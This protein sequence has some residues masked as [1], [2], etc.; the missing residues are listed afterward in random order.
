MKDDRNFG[1]LLPVSSLPSGEGIGTLGKEAYDFIDFLAGS[2][3]KIWQVLPLNPTNYGD[4]PYQSCSSDALNYYFIDLNMLCRDGLLK[5]SEIVPEE[6]ADTPLRVNY[7]RQFTKKIELLKKAFSRFDG[8]KEFE[9]FVKKGEYCDFAVFMAIKEKFN[10]VAWTEWEQ[11][12]RKYDEKTVTNF[13]KENKNE[14]L[15]WQFTQFIFLKQWNALKNY[16]AS[17]GVEIMGD[18]PL[19]VAYD[20]VEVWKYGGELFKVD[21]DR[22]LKC[23]AGCPPDGFTADGQLWGNPVYNWERMRE[24]GYDWWKARIEKCF[25]LFDILRIDHFRGF[26]RY[27]EVPA[28]DSTARY[29]LW[30]DGPKEELFKDI[31]DYKIV[32]E[33]LGVIDDGVRRLMKNVG[34]PGMKVLEFAFDGDE[35]NEHKPSN[36]TENFVCYTGTHDNMPLKQYIDD[37]SEEERERFISDVE[38]ESGLLKLTALTETSEDLCRSVVNLAFASKADTVIIPLWD[39]LALGGEARINKPSTVSDSNWS[40]R[41]LKEDFSEELS[42]YLKKVSQRSKRA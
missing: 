23:V 2:G 25:K 16:A 24:S 11:P 26:D 6:L 39:L 27:W 4:S 29:G 7:G 41:F 5:K 15:F 10:H 14:Y 42:A 33:D 3:G 37:L 9:E 12:F 18:I 40:R 36:F 21:E 28:G 35:T 20:S 13:V 22:R 32:A 19:Y 34:Y 31:S 8:G 30:E 38:K 1:I 17:H